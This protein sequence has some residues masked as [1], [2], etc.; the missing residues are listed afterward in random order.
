MGSAIEPV[1]GIVFPRLVPWFSEHV[2]PVPSLTA[3]VIGHGRSNITY[4]LESPDGQACVLRRPPLSHVLPTAHDMRREYR[5]ISALGG[6]G[7]PV[8]QAI[9][10]CEDPEVIGA[11]FYIMSFVEGMVPADP[12]AFAARFP[13]STRRGIGENLIDTLADLHAVDPAEVGLSDFGKPAGFVARQVRRFAGQIEQHKT[14]RPFPELPELARRLQNALPEESGEFSIVHGDYRIDNCVLGDD[15]NIAAILDWEMS[16]LGD[17]LTDVGLI[18]MYW[19]DAQSG[20]QTGV[21]SNSVTA[22]PGFLSRR[23]AME[24]YAKRSGRD[25]ANLDFYILLAHFKLAVIVEGIYARFLEGGTVG[26]GFESTGA[27][28][29]NLARSGLAIADRSSVAALRGA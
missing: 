19:N 17:P 4:R 20:S 6:T 24:R 9:A 3:S 23:E 15:G 22:Q 10:L 29:V 13:P 12:V 2:R 8:P 7:I 27:Q 26:T 5:V 1:P 18:Y 16:S 21:A 11:Q 14:S 28:A 25:L